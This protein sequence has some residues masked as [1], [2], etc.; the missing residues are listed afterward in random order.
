MAEI[1]FGIYQVE[2]LYQHLPTMYEPSRQ[3]IYMVILSGPGGA[4]HHVG[5][6]E[7]DLPPHTLLYV[8]PDRLSCFDKRLTIG[9]YVLLFSE[10]F[11]NRSQR[12]TFFLQHLHLFHDFD[13]AYYGE[14]PEEGLQ[15]SKVI[16]FL[17]Y[18]ARNNFAGLRK[19]LAHNLVEQI[20]ILGSMYFKSINIVDFKE[21]QDNFLV[22][23]YKLLISKHFTAEKSVH[24]YADKM[25]ITERRLHHAVEHV[26]GMGAKDL[27]IAHVMREAKW[28]LI[29]SPLTV[30]E[31][32]LQ[33][34][35]SGEQNFSTFFL[36]HEGMR[37]TEFRKLS[38]Y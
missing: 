15:Y 5:G 34:G 11:Y 14:L 21:G 35:F 1:D 36:N 32:S 20:L 29:H 6:K 4:K 18:A 24:F 26:I 33:L 22:T 13:Q 2:K 17:L 19:D 30:K 10:K 25:N 7:I 3:N 8:G 37:P 28:Q 23:Q 27:I 16:V 12:D 38:H 31:I 9:T